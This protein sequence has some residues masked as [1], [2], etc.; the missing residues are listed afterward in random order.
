VRRLRLVI[1]FLAVAG[2]LAYLRDP[3]WLAGQ[4]TGLRPWQRTADGMAFRWSGGH[5]SFFV[6]ADAQSIHVPISTTFDAAGA[7]PMV[8]TFTLDDVRAAR[9]MLTDEAWVDVLVPIPPRGSRR[10][11]RI[12][13]RTSVTR[14]DNRGVKIGEVEVIR[15]TRNASAAASRDLAAKL[16]R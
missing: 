14:D 10:V 15:A 8:V 11:R 9:V 12:D 6:P 3:A 2:A 7:R 4:T 5:A 1:L 13:V 16:L